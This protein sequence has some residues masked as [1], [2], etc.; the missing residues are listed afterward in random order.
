MSRMG[1]RIAA[2]DPG[3]GRAAAGR[4]GPAFA[5]APAVALG[6][7]LAGL[8]VAASACAGARDPIV[9]PD[10]GSALPTATAPTFE[11]GPAPGGLSLDRPSGW[12]AAAEDESLLMLVGPEV[13]GSE[14][15]GADDAMFMA[16]C[17]LDNV[18]E[19]PESAIDAFIESAAAEGFV[20]VEGPGPGADPDVL[21]S[22]AADGILVATL[23]HDGGDGQ[24][25]QISPALRMRIAAAMGP[26]GQA[27]FFMGRGE[28]AAWDRLGPIF[29]RM[30]ESVRAE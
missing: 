28:Q 24:G 17:G 26:G 15:F 27:C 30:M 14:H 13:T 23:E 21:G 20:P 25:N 16:A 12:W 19:S 1:P 8:G 5:V 6:V 7:A 11:P 3:V 18:G 29:E 4:R 2:H 22:L 10:L 9:A